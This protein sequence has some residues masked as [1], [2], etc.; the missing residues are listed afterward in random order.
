MGSALKRSN[1]I[2]AKKAREKMSM[3]LSGFEHPVFVEIDP[4][5]NVVTFTDTGTRQGY[6]TRM[7]NMLAG[8][9]AMLKRAELEHRQRQAQQIAAVEKAKAEG[10]AKPADKGPDGPETPDEDPGPP[11]GSELPSASAEE[12]KAMVDEVSGGSLSPESS[13]G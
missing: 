3:V 2:A 4:K 7:S 13:G 1:K 12:V 11:V 6:Q 5:M 9:F 10:E 8:T